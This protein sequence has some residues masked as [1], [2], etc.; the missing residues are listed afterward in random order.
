MFKNKRA[1]WEKLRRFG[2][3]KAAGGTQGYSTEIVGGAFRLTVTV[4]KDGTV[5]AK[6]IDAASQE[7]YVVHR[8]AGAAGAFVGRVKAECESV[9][10]AIA[11]QCFDS[12][13]F[14]GDVAHGVIG[15]LRDAYHDELEFLWPRFPR[16]AVV[17]RK[18]TGKWYG[19]LLDVSKRTLGLP[20]DE[21]IDVL[22]LRVAPDD[23]DALVDGKRYFRGYHMNK[24][25]WCSIPL[26]GSVPLPDLLPRIAASHALAR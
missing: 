24:K 10:A 2:F 11:E 19:A 7:E 9:L 8:T 17:R 23:L 18:D 13:V 20:S 21:I 14:G 12:D 15:H 6:V 1:N 26:D 5:G 16:C 4:Q 3:A 25:H 22:N